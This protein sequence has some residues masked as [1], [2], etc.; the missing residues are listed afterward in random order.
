MPGP[1]ASILNE[2]SDRPFSAASAA[3]DGARRLGQLGAGGQ[4]PEE[5]E[6]GLL[7]AGP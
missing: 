6:R 4:P 2:S 3:G 7:A 1:I 5:P